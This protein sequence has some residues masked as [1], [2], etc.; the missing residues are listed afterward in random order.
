MTD[1]FRNVDLDADSFDVFTVLSHTVALKLT[2]S[3]KQAT[4]IS[5]LHCQYEPIFEP[6]IAG[7]MA[8]LP[9]LLVKNYHEREPE[10]KVT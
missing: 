7:V 8:S 2:E 10:T 5:V 9:M 1:I 3:D 6:I 4:S